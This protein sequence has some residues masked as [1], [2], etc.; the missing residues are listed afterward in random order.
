MV[1]IET[2][3]VRSIKCLDVQI[4]FAP[5]LWIGPGLEQMHHINRGVFNNA[6]ALSAIECFLSERKHSPRCLQ[7]LAIQVVKCITQ[8]YKMAT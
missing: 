2:V 3:L 5:N 1:Q 7:A 8:K 4:C 6:S